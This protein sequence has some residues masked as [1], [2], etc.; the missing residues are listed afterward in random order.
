MMFSRQGQRV[1]KAFEMKFLWRT[2]SRPYPLPEI[3]GSE[4]AGKYLVGHC[5]I[6]GDGHDRANPGS[7]PGELL[8]HQTVQQI[9]SFQRTHHHLEMRD[10]TVIA[11]GDDVDA[12]DFDALDLVFE[13][14]DRA[15]LAAPLAG[16]FE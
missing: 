16:I 11:E 3:L 9:D 8:P 13:F 14:E 12:V 1:A 5:D 7:L 10:L 4:Q 15:I 2:G 6:S